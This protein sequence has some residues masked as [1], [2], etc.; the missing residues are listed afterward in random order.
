MCR[1]GIS[2]RAGTNHISA[3]YLE[4]VPGEGHSTDQEIS[5]LEGCFRVGWV[6]VGMWTG[7]P[8][9]LSSLILV[10]TNFPGFSSL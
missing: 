8:C 3:G 4:L 1:P 10:N 6:G 5:G 2:G 9:D 7:G